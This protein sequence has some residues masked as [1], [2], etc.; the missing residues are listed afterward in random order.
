MTVGFI[1]TLSAY[2]VVAVLLLSFNIA[3]RWSWW[4]KA[5]GIIVTSAFFVVSYY[6]IIDMMGWPVEAQL[7]ERFQLHWARVS[8][9]DRLLNTPGAIYVWV[10]EM[11]EQNIPLGTPRAYKLPYSE[12]LD[13]GVNDAMDMIS[14][15]QEVGG[16]SQIYDQDEDSGTD[17]EG[18]DPELE[19]QLEAAGAEGPASGGVQVNDTVVTLQEL[20]A[21]QLPGKDATSAN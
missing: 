19:A 17:E 1:G 20:Q 8:E 4:V 15:G 6:S 21:V 16:T 10:E 7:P 12:P 3:P 18:M 14:M 5:T 2:V 9:P 11:D 13:N